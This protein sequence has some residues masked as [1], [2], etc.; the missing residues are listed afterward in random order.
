MWGTYIFAGTNVS[1]QR[2]QAGCLMMCREQKKPLFSVELSRRLEGRRPRLTILLAIFDMVG[3]F[4][5]Q[6]TV[7][8]VINVSLVVAS[9]LLILSCL[10]LRRHWSHGAP[11]INS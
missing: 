4:I 11:K 6:G 8:V 9:A 10:E 5:A 3:E 7:L 2:V 1:T